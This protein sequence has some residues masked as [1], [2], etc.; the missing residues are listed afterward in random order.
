MLSRWFRCDNAK[1]IIAGI[2]LNE[3]QREIVD[4]GRAIEPKSRFQLAYTQQLKSRSNYTS[5]SIS[6]KVNYMTENRSLGVQEENKSAL[7]T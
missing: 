1:W 2:N 3:R 7:L 5:S 6:S 4:H